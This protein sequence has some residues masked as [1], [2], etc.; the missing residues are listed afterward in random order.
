MIATWLDGST[1]EGERGSLPVRSRALLFSVC[2]L[3]IRIC[4]LAAVIVL[5]VSLAGCDTS[6]KRAVGYFTLGDARK[7]AEEGDH[8]FEQERILLRYNDE[9]FSA[10]STECPY[11]GAV[12]VRAHEG[13]AVV[14]RS[15]LSGSTYDEYGKV[16]RGPSTHN[17]PFYDVR[18]DR[19]SYN[20]TIPTLFVH[21]GVERPETWRLKLP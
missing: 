5:V 7:L 6:R 8:H 19:N 9:G 3:C 2:D 17:L 16:I 1:G 21:V 20:G 18:V 13:G 4:S 14:W 12:L 11:D 15:P 10:M